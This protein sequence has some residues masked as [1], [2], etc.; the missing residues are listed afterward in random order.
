MSEAKQLNKYSLL[1]WDDDLQTLKT[2]QKIN[3]PI[4]TERLKDQL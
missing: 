3:C 1:I 2:N 4:L